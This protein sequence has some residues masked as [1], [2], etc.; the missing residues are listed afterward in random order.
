[1]GFNGIH[2][3]NPVPASGGN[4][5]SG[6]GDNSYNR[7]NPTLVTVGGLTA[8]TVLTGTVQD[9][10]DKQLFPYQ[11]PYFTG[12]GISGQSQLLE[13]GAAIAAG[14]KTFVWTDAN[15]GNITA[16]SISIIDETTST[17]LASGLANSGTTNIAVSAIPN[18]GI[19]SHTWQIQGTNSH[20]GAFSAQFA[21]AWHPRRFA[22]TVPAANL[23]ALLGMTNSSDLAAVSG[24]SFSIND[25]TY[26]KPGAGTYNCTGGKYIWFLWDATLGDGS[27]TS[28]GLGAAMQPKQVVS[29]T[30]ANGITRNYYLYVTTNPQ[31]GSAVQLTA[32]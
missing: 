32:N 4:G 9:A 5:G 24:I 16:N 20:S 23:S 18:T 7:S 17:T 14:T 31:N 21:V 8:G 10:L 6:G 22:G 12:F 11:A 19:T 30:N 15:S 25:L 1:M 26:S 3:F 28:N 29:F 27:F 2:E 13:I